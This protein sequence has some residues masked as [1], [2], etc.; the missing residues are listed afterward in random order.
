MKDFVETVA[1][2]RIYQRAYFRTRNISDLQKAKAY[3]KKVDDMIARMKS[4][5]MLF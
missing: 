2:M 1:Q 5:P 3:E 4:E